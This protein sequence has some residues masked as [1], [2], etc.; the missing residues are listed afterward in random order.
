VDADP[1]VAEPGLRVVRH[2]RPASHCSRLGLG[3][4]YALR[5]RDILARKGFD[6]Q[7]RPTAGSIDNLKRLAAEADG[8]DVA[9][10]QGGLGD[11]E[12]MPSSRASVGVSP[13]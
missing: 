10:V 12:K 11:P 13:G 7:L 6:L 2:P 1:G 9:L 3:H 4:R 5:Y 8:V